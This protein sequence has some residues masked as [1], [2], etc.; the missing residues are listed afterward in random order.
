MKMNKGLYGIGLQDSGILPDIGGMEYMRWLKE[1]KYRI[2]ISLAA[3]FA[4]IIVMTAV[5]G[6][7]E[8]VFF[9]KRQGVC[10]QMKAAEQTESM[11]TGDSMLTAWWGTLYPKFCFSETS[12][13]SEVKISFWLAKVLGWC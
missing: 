9:A 5:P 11:D 6:T 7:G 12:S 8:R 10:D 1:R 13:G 2:W 4:W 3:G